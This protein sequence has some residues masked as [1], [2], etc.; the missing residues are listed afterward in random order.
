MDARSR[1][2]SSFT[3]VKGSLIE[4]T[5]SIFRDWDYRVSKFENLRRVRDENTIG[6]TST[7]WALTVTKVMNRRFDPAGPQ[8]RAPC[9]SCGSACRPT[10]KQS[11]CGGGD[12]R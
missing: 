12:H 7:N 5:Y 2:V 3:I 1:V 9:G 10:R 6:A 11:G 4:E 8:A